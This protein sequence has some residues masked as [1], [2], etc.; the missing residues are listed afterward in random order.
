MNTGIIMIG[1]SLV[2][3]SVG[4]ISSPVSAA[5]PEGSCGSAVLLPDSPQGTNG[6]GP[7]ETNS[8]SAHP[9]T[10]GGKGTQSYGMP[11]GS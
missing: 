1:L 7:A 11:A 10:R 6:F 8:T 9:A 3:L 2:L 5:L 4:L